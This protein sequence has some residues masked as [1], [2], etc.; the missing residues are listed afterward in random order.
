MANNHATLFLSKA[1]DGEN[2]DAF[3]KNGVD[4]RLFVSKAEKEA[5]EYIEQYRKENGSMPSYAVV[6][7][8]VDGFHYVPGVTDS[9]EY[10]AN[11]MRTRKA[12]IDFNEYM[13]SKDT[14]EFINENK[15]DMDKVISKLTSDLESINVRYTNT[16]SIGVDLKKGRETYLA[17]YQDRKEGKSFRTWESSFD[18]I[19]RELGGYTSGNLYTVFGKSGRGKSAIVLRDV[20][21]MAMQGATVLLWSLEMP[22]FE[23]MTRLYT[24]LS[25]KLGL[26]KLTVEGQTMMAGFDSGEIR[27]GQ[28]SPMYEDVFKKML[29][30]IEDNVKGTVIVRGVDDEGFED[31]TVAQLKKDAET[32][33]ADVVVLDPVYYMDYE[34]NRS[35]TA[36][37]D[38]S[39]TSKMLRRAAGSLNVPIIG[40]TQGEESDSET[41]TEDIRELSLPKRKEV[42]KTKS[43]L[44]DA[45]ALIAIDTDYRQ[46]RGI[47][48]I[49][50]GRNGGEGT[51]AEITFIPSH[52]IIKELS[53]DVSEFDF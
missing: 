4:E 24:M 32:V 51:T 41:S 26:T 3:S 13:S 49:Q 29:A 52:G 21:E 46:R 35:K 15:G 44:E 48:G 47:I 42:K 34:Q 33:E 19:N 18:Y 31:R 45:T 16:R 14:S 20:L 5:Y 17:E 27:N 30:E 38:A 39:E 8:A 50:K 36:G 10:L 2:H 37:G 7:D 23:V 22:G 9:F 1:I 28:L 12:Q 40:M 25:A 11:Q 53:I 43:L 6:V